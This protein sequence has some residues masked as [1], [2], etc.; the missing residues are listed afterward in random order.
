MIVKFTTSNAINKLAIACLFAVFG[1]LNAQTLIKSVYIDFGINSGMYASPAGLFTTNP[2]ANGNYWNN[3]DNYLTTS[4]PATALLSNTNETSGFSIT[5]T[6]AFPS[7]SPNG[8]ANGGFN[9]T[10]TVEDENSPVKFLPSEFQVGTAGYDFFYFTS[11][12]STGG[13][14]FK[15]SGLNPNR[16][17]RFRI[18]AS[19]VNTQ[20]RITSFSLVGATTVT[21]NIQTSGVNLGSSGFNLNNSTILTLADVS[22]TSNGELLLSAWVSSGAGYINFLKIE[23]YDVSTKT[24]KNNMDNSISL[25]STKV[26]NEL[27][28]NFASNAQS[29]S[30]KVLDLQGRSLIAEQGVNMHTKNINVAHLAKGIYLLNVVQG[31]KSY[32]TKFIKE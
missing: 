12:S 19:R 10:Y 27:E 2:D 11:T 18:F 13:P 8:Y 26:T 16:S 24:N 9:G 14:Q 25:F 7:N 28:V 5:L 15:F 1:N 30:I 23:E 29:A 32:S 22:P 4:N 17:Y 21:G 3:Y 20:D 6:R 31:D